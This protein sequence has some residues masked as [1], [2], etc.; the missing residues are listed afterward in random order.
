MSDLKE[1]DNLMII[2][3][4]INNTLLSVN[5]RTVDK[6]NKDTVLSNN[7][8]NN[9]DLIDM[10]VY[11]MISEYTFFKERLP[12]LITF[13]FMEQMSVNLKGLKW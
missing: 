10:S 6:I 9:T 12:K 5:A 4:D 7:V 11:C 13:W 1:I 2:M 3:G 8:I